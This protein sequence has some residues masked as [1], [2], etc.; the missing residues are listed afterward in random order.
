MCLETVISQ[1]NLPKYLVCW[2]IFRVMPNGDLFGTFNGQETFRRGK[3]YN[4]PSPK[5]FRILSDQP[6]NADQYVQ[7]RRGYH[8]YRSRGKA[9][10]RTRIGDVVAKVRLS[11]LVAHGVQSGAH[12]Y[13][14]R[15]MYIYFKKEQ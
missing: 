3:T 13:V 8:A 1:R 10:G 14:G 11:S 2:K 15:K 12:V 6:R 7:Y 5:R 4:D 9:L